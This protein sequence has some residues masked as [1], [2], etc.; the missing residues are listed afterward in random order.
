MPTKLGDYTLG[1][2]L[3]DGAT[4]KVKLA[5]NSENRRFAIKLIHN[6]SD[7][8]EAVAAEI[9]ALQKLKHP[10]VVNLIEYGQGTK[11]NSKK[12]S[13]QVNYLVLELAQGGELFDFISETGAFSEPVA[14]F[15]FK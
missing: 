2:T 1:R 13:K 8:L 9:E 5:K 12:G 7:A 14:R 6:Q 4:G 11:E 3:G 10:N 15:Y